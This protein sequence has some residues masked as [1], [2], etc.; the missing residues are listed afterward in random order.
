[1]GVLASALAGDTVHILALEPGTSARFLDLYDF[2]TGAY[3]ES[4]AVPTRASSFAVDGSVVYFA[5]QEPFPGVLAVRP[6]R[7]Q[8]G[9]GD[10]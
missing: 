9:G 10:S 5:V 6:R 4:W 7:V 1:V 8:R 3:L 2:E